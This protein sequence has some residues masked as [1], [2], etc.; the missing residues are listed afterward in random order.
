[1]I[2]VFCELIG[3]AT[4]HARESNPKKYKNTVKYTIITVVAEYR[5]KM[6]QSGQLPSKKYRALPW[7][8]STTVGSMY[9]SGRLPP[10]KH[11]ALPWG[12]STTVACTRVVDYHKK[13]T[14]H[15]LGV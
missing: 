6:Y 5:S 2:F 4:P 3:I 11:R 12:L 9:Q 15:Y 7:G 14:V 1:M 10:K 8:L 13:N